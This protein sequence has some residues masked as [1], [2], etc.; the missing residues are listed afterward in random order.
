MPTTSSSTSSQAT[1][2]AS[3]FGINLVAQFLIGILLPLIGSSAGHPL[4]PILYCVA[5][6]AHWSF[7]IGLVYG[8]FRLFG[9]RADGLEWYY[10]HVPVGLSSAGDAPPQGDSI[11]AGGGA[12][13]SAPIGS[14]IKASAPKSEIDWERFFSVDYIRYAG[15]ILIVSS[16]FAFLFRIEWSLPY[17][18]IASFL[19]A[20]AAIVFAEVG[21]RKNKELLAGSCFLLSFALAQF[22]FTLLFKYF[23]QDA[24]ASL[25]GS[26]ET[27]IVVKTIFTALGIVGLTRYRAGYL[28]VVFFIIAYFTPLSL[29]RVVPEIPLNSELGFV[30]VMSLITLTFGVLRTHYEVTLVNVLSANCYALSLFRPTRA[31]WEILSKNLALVDGHNVNQR[32]F[33]VFVGLALLFVLHIVAGMF[34]ALRCKSA[35]ESSSGAEAP[36]GN[37]SIDAQGDWTLAIFQLLLTQVIGAISLSAVQTNIPAIEG[38]VGI[39]LLISSM[40][41]FCSYFV[42]R[43][44]GLNNS[45]TE[46]LLNSALFI[47]TIG[48]FLHVHEPW[49]A[50][51]FLVFSCIV[52]YV[53][54]VLGTLRTRVYAFAALTVS[55]IKLYSEC[56]ELFDSISGTA[57]ILVIGVVLM[58]LSYKLEDVKSLLT[59]RKEAAP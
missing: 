45:Y 58:V 32:N 2:Q 1:T 12:R 7:A 5:A 4:T 50:I 59:N 17:K 20:A 13:Q 8:F 39:T 18:I 56:N 27:W 55:M 14:F 41:S 38:F 26:T 46:V 42:L 15:L 21:Q 52:I 11:T 3:R 23:A 36:T 47:S 29:L 44:S 57:V 51:V 43:T 6:L 34:H 31:P 53:S 33:A 9:A 35:D 25:L 48:M 24:D 10:Q 49:T 37:R 22:G 19:G 40:V 30:I 16:L 54:F 28:P